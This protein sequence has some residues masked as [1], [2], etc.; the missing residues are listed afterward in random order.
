MNHKH[1]LRNFV[2]LWAA[3]FVI[4]YS[5]QW[6]VT[7]RLD[8]KRPDYAVVWS[9]GETQKYSNKGKIYLEEPWF[10][11]QVAWDS[12]YY[13][14]IAV[15]GYDDPAA[16]R[17]QD[18]KT[19]IDWP[20]NY[21]F[22]PIYPYLI[23]LLKYPLAFLGLTQIA[24]SALA[25]LMITLLGSLAGMLALWDLTRDFFD[26]NDALR[27]G[28]YMLI[29]PSAFFFAQV[30]T[31]GLFVGLAFWTLALSRRKH[32]FWAGVLGLIAS[33]TRA[34]GGLLFIPLGLAWLRAVDWRNISKSFHWRWILQGFWA[35]LPLIGYLLWRTS[36][37]GQGWAA[38]QSFYFGRGVLTLQSSIESWRGAYEYALTTNAG[39]IY[40]MMEVF[41]VLLALIA[42]LVLMRKQLEVA[43]FSLTIVIFSVFS[44]SA[45]SEARYMLVA[46][47]LFISLALFGRNKTFDRTWTLISLLLM[48]MSVMLYSF[49]MWVG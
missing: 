26:D 18:P 46:P 4:V 27:A 39:L 49:D 30:Y 24:T 2:F 37:L 45:Q 34:H 33:G 10:N 42:S 19:G 25:G 47:A 16:G 21:S 12:E 14:G 36:S 38:L 17:A 8:I 7:A 11:R 48:G 15:G 3:W 6:L 35:F 31:E 28:F 5:F 20:K 41:S 32:W 22:F 40:F 1:T 29:F 44:G 13:L 23:R 43:A 9:A